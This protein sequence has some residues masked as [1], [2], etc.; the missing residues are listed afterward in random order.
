[1]GSKEPEKK[2]ASFKKP[3]EKPRE[4]NKKE[5]YKDEPITV[6]EKA[7]TEKPDKTRFENQTAKPE[8]KHVTINENI[9]KNVENEPIKRVEPI[10]KLSHSISREDEKIQV[11]QGEIQRKT[12]ENT[13]ELQKEVLTKENIS[14]MHSDNK[15]A[16]VNSQRVRMVKKKKKK[17]RSDSEIETIQFDQLNDDGVKQSESDEIVTEQKYT[18]QEPESP[19]APLLGKKVP[20]HDHAQRN[21][22]V[23]EISP[24]GIEQPKSW[25]TGEKSQNDLIPTIMEPKPKEDDGKIDVQLKHVDQKQAQRSQKRKQQASRNLL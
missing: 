12:I 8:D 23:C 16:E 9:S 18:V 11:K 7:K 25:P 1:M 19:A 14:P 3:V 6:S 21:I 2:R 17:A 22:E 5:T 20:H 10:K 13:E 15:E 24:E 4:E